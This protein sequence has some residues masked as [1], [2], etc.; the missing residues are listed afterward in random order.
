[1]KNYR[2][3][4]RSDWS[5][6]KMGQPDS[7]RSRCTVVNPKINYYTVYG[8]DLL[9]VPSRKARSKTVYGC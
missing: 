7:F 5:G 2:P 1:M 6:A 8:V 4:S 3:F 9:L